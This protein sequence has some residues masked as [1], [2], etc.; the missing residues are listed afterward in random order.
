MRIGNGTI[1]YEVYEDGD[2]FCGI[3]E[4]TLPDLA[5]ATTEVS[6]AGISGKFTAPFIGQMEAMSLSLSFKTVE[7]R[8]ANLTMPGYHNLD[9]RVA[10]Q[11]QNS[12]TGKFNVEKIKHLVTVTPVKNSPGK[13]APSSATESTVEF[14]VSYYAQF[15]DGKKVV[16]FDLFNCIYYLNGV[17]YM[18]EVRKA[19]GKE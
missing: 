5:Q 13:I 12:T 7:E 15:I 11:T 19:M 16:E 9:L 10:Q 14:S 18:A 3:A 8:M 17:D 1:N 6:G 2:N 4:V